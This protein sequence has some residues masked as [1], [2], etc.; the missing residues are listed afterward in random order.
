MHAVQLL[1]G[2]QNLNLSLVHAQVARCTCIVSICD[3]AKLEICCKIL[4]LMTTMT[5]IVRVGRPAFSSLGTFQAKRQTAN[6][7]T[8]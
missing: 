7:T 3:I 1:P 4:R 8:D 6:L 5:Y 2:Y